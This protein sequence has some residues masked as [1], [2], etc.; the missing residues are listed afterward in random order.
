VGRLARSERQAEFRD[1]IVPATVTTLI[2][3]LAALCVLALARRRLPA[4]VQRALPIAAAAMLGTLPATFFSAAVG[5]DGMAAYVALLAGGGAL[6]AAAAWLAE[7]RWPRT[8]SIVSVGSVVVLIAVDV[9]VGAPLQ[10]NTVFGYSVA[11]A[12][13]FAGVGNL[14]F[15]LLGSGAIVLAALVAER[16]DRRGKRVALGLLLAVLLIDGLPV[17]GADV[18]GVLSIVPAFG[19][20]ALVLLGRRI[21]VREVVA[22]SAAA[23]G[24]L[25]MVAF[26]DLA[27]PDADQTHLARLAQHIVDQ[28]WSPFFSSLTRRWSASFGSGQTGAW[29]VFALLVGL[30]AVYLAVRVVGR[31]RTS[32]AVPLL[33]PAEQ[34]AAIGLAVLAA[35]GLVANDSSF[36][37]PATMLLIIAPVVLQRL[38]IAR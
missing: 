24:M 32:P 8:G 30:V 12:G 11:V 23:F 10:L 34:A 9:L 7:R 18:G 4:W 26:I 13:R 36:A 21:G 6:V 5:V 31:R 15:A 27:R 37:V 22:V 3:L 33:A 17:L 29:V 25:V 16:F 28:R 35:L 38:D 1:S 20:A 14:A 19:L 2:V